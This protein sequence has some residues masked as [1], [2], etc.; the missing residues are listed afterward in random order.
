MLT[1]NEFETRTGY[2]MSYDEYVK[3]HC[4]NCTKENCPHRNAFRRLP[5]IDG[6]LGLCPNLKE[7]AE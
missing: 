2:K 1:R 4:P 6:G 7:N 5:T 3:T